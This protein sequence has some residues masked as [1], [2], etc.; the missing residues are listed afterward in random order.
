MAVGITIR[1]DLINAFRERINEIVEKRYGGGTKLTSHEV[2]CEVSLNIFDKGLLKEISRMEPF[3][4]GN[5]EPLFLVK[6]ALIKDKKMVLEKY[7]KYLVSDNT[8]DI[9][10]ISFDSGMNLKIGYMYDILFTAGVNNGYV[11]FS[12]KDAF[13]SNIRG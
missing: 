13:L 11:S 3:G 4:A 6:H 1:S 12:I 8:N 2:D 9:W 7:P 5:E 10:M